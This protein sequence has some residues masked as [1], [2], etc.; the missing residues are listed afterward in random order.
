MG[1]KQISDIIKKKMLRSIYEIIQKYQYIFLFFCVFLIYN[2]NFRNINSIDTIPASLLPFALLN[3]HTPQLDMFLSFI[4]GENI[5]A[6]VIIGNHF[7]SMYPI[8]TPIL[9]T[10]LYVIPYLVIN[11]LHIPLDMSNSSF[12]LTVFAMEKISAS[13]I[14]SLAIVF[15]FAGLKEIINKKIALI[16]ALI[17]AFGTNMWSI[18]SQAL[19]QHGMVALLFS[20]M[21]FLIVTNEKNEHLRNYL[22]L[23][24]C[25]SLLVFNRPSDS[26]MVLP[27][28]VY[29]FYKNIR[30]FIL[31]CLIVFVSSLPVMFYNIS[32]FHNIF[33]GYSSMATGLGFKLEIL[34]PSIGS[35]IIT[36]AI[37]LLFSPQLGLFI[38][39]PIA[40]VAIFG[41]FK[42]YSIP[43]KT[44]RFF[45]YSFAVVLILETV[46]FA[47]W[48]WNFHLHAENGPGI[49]FGPR[50]FSGFLPAICILIGIFLNSLVNPENSKFK[51][52]SL[53]KILIVCVISV[54]VV[55]SVFAQI[56]GAF[57]YPNGNWQEF[58]QFTEAQLGDMMDTA[59]LKTFNEGPIIVN[60]INILQNLERRND[61]IDPTTDFAIKMGTNLDKGWGIL[62]YN[63]SQQ[64]RAIGNYSSISVQY[65]KYSITENNCTLSMVASSVNEP[66]SMMIFVNNKFVNNFSIT[67]NYE[68]IKTSVILKSSLRMG[69]NIIEFKIP[70]NCMDL[71]STNTLK[72][73]RSGTCMKI[74]NLKISCR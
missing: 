65:M 16:T 36:Q 2:L 7:Y 62:V 60:P 67:N 71:S 31:Y 6:F 22:L 5:G 41:F 42:I 20:V 74:Q 61:I 66:R 59:I 53:K 9:V 17:F 28:V 58:P 49:M 45:F 57:Y 51:M 23:G 40:L 39:T 27:I 68:Q 64:V 63:E 70:D 10:P 13:C 48:F 11:F 72:N 33:G 12:F 56:V 34:T 24:V 19:W 46:V 50:Y 14:S 18:C 52:A 30:S 15:F 4:Q 43:N 38:F 47:L 1:S 29:V 69:N 35:Q 37:G 32:L 44:L 54:F 3:S 55:W 73:I 8:V 25:S 21:F 26:F